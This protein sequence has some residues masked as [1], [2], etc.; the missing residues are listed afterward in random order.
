MVVLA[1]IIFIN[2]CIRA[3]CC[4]NKKSHSERLR[5]NS[6]SN[7]ERRKEINNRNL[8]NDNSYYKI[9]TK[10]HISPLYSSAVSSPSV[11]SP[12]YSPSNSTH[13]VASPIYTLNSVETYY[14]KENKNYNKN[15]KNSKKE[16]RMLDSTPS[17][18]SY[19][20]IQVTTP[21]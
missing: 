2:S 6:A 17:A 3:I 8:N 11:V 10:S 1:L 20:H 14:E 9:H 21:I 5:A 4:K 15:N 16:I 12:I 18:P 7:Y 19:S 13:K